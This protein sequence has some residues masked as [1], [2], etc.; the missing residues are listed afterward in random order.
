MKNSTN[1]KN[2]HCIISDMDGCMVCD[3]GK[4]LSSNTQVDEHQKYVNKLEAKWRE[5]NEK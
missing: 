3:C 2:D 4:K 5:E 1:I